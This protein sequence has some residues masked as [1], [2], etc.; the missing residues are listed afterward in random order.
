M[1]INIIKYLL[2]DL[3]FAIFSTKMEQ[4]LQ[5]RL[6]MSKNKLLKLKN[7]LLEVAR[8][9]EVR[10]ESLGK[11]RLIQVL[12]QAQKQN[13]KQLQNPKR[14]SLSPL[15]QHEQAED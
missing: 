3:Y 2:Y 1:T 9:E 4:Y 11:N 12:R 5:L 15:H 14:Q 6:K 8:E 7:A 13:L 10:D